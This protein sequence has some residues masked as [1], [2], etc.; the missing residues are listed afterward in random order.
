MARRGQGFDR[1]RDDAQPAAGW[2][3]RLG[4]HQRDGMRAAE[5]PAERAL[6]EFRR[7]RED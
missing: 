6:G 5:D 2:T 4:E 3:I 7:S 1:A